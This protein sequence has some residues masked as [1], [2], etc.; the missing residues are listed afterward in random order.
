MIVISKQFN[1]NVFHSVNNNN[2]HA[3]CS[4]EFLH[5]LLV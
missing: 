3:V 4:V 1:N 2:E 5:G